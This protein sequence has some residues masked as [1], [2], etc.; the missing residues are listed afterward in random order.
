[1]GLI[2][3]SECGKK[4]SDKALSCPECSC[5]TSVVMNYQ[6]K[7]FYIERL[8]ENANSLKNLD[9]DEK[10]K[11]LCECVC[12]LFKIKNEKDKINFD[13]SLDGIKNLLKKTDNIDERYLTELGISNSEEIINFISKMLL[14][15]ELFDIQKKHNEKL[16]TSKR[17]SDDV[18]K[19]SIESEVEYYYKNRQ[20][21][22]NGVLYKVNDSLTSTRKE[23]NSKTYFYS[24]CKKGFVVKETTNIFEKLFI[25]DKELI[26]D[27]KIANGIC[28]MYINQYILKYSLYCFLKEKKKVSF[29]DISD[30]IENELKYIIPEAKNKDIKAY[31]NILIAFSK[32][33]YKTEENDTIILYEKDD[34]NEK[35]Y[36]KWYKSY[37]KYFKFV[38]QYLKEN[39]VL[40]LN[41]EEYNKIKIDYKSELDG[42]D[43]SRLQM[44]CRVLVCNNILKSDKSYLV[45]ENDVQLLNN[46]RD[47]I[48]DIILKKEDISKD[49]LE[50]EIY[51]KMNLKSHLN[52]YLSKQ[53]HNCLEELESEK[54]LIMYEK[55]EE[56]F[57]SIFSER[58]EKEKELKKQEEIEHIRAEQEEM[59]NFFTAPEILCKEIKLFTLL[60]SKKEVYLNYFKN[61]EEFS[62]LSKLFNELAYNYNEYARAVLSLPMQQYK[63]M[64]SST[65]GTLGTI[66]GGLSAGILASERAE[67]KM[68]EYNESQRQ[69]FSSKSKMDISREKTEKCYYMIEKIIYKNIETRNNWIQSRDEYI[70]NLKSSKNVNGGCYVAT[71]VYGSYDC[72]QVWTLRRYRDYNLAKTWHGRL[73]I[74]MYYAFSPIIV[75]L[76]GKT[77][78]FKE[79][80]KRKLDKI[81]IKLQN[82]GYESTPYQDINWR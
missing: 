3:C 51:Q 37:E 12:L 34:N 69:Y 59:N 10:E 49:N 68:A 76:F 52:I 77:K 66:A 24:L 5:P 72:P 15:F 73:F 46:L 42:L 23:L 36:L 78:W 11:I 65:A 43:Y 45:F 2:K 48:K 67:K 74:K 55:N 38:S 50:K 18:I 21:S 54:S 14:F 56:F 16:E 35:E 27:C 81:I 61:S 26:E 28:R 33:Y 62:E 79:I 4:Y 30:F 32:C 64:S 53:I 1:M 70:S 71:C 25:Y 20:N 19:E 7:S 63:P 40:N 41:T 58:I 44:I 47:S 17:L 75:K 39:D 22:K 60:S 57:V 9:V 82:L 29:N 13:D 8:K 80:C 6:D 31:V